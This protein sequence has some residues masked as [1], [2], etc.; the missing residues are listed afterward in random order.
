M[1]M[2]FSNKMMTKFWSAVPRSGW[3]E[4][5]S[6]ES[7][8]CGILHLASS[9]AL[10]LLWNTA[11]DLNYKKRED[12]IAVLLNLH[13]CIFYACSTLAMVGIVKHKKSLLIPALVCFPL[14]CLFSVALFFA[15]IYF[16]TQG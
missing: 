16:Q 15:G 9:V 8:K 12:W 1:V 7:F 6:V 13:S 3:F 5:G 11:G 10:V 14:T 2:V 4:L